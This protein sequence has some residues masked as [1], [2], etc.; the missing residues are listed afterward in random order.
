LPATGSKCTPGIP[1]P[2]TSAD[3]ATSSVAALDARVASTS[4]LARSRPLSETQREWLKLGDALGVK[5]G[6]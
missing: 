6:V 3:L 2:P 4:A 5:A 1:P